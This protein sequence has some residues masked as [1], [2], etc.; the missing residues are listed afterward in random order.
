MVEFVFAQKPG[1]Y[2]S[3]LA[4]VLSRREIKFPAKSLFAVVLPSSRPFVGRG[5]TTH[6]S[7]AAAIKQ[8][9]K[10][11]RQGFRHQIID[12]SGRVY[13]ISYFEGRRGLIYCYNIQEDYQD[14][15]VE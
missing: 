8:S 13:E 5:Y 11:K 3:D 2:G 15:E 14:E 9:L 4:C 6:R 7:A 1:E 10:L 12:S